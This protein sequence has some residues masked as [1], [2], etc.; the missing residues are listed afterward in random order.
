VSDARPDPAAAAPT[1]SQRRAPGAAAPGPVR[2]VPQPGVR[3]LVTL[4]VVAFSGLLVL[5]VLAGVPFVA[6]AV[7]L[8]GGV[9]AWGWAG[10]LGLPSPRGTTSVLAFGTAAAVLTGALTR[11]DP[12]LRWMPAA[13]ALSMLVAFLHQLLRRDGRPRLVESVVS[14]VTGLAVVVSG[15][16]LVPLALTADGGSVMAVAGAALGVAALV[17]LLARRVRLRP[18]LVPMAL[19][20]GTA[21]AVGVAA[22]FGS[23]SLPAAGLLGLFCAAV[24]STLRGVLGLLPAMSG[25]RSQLACA[26]AS[27]LGCGVVVYVVARLLVG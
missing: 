12:F 11:T 16:C 15:A 4:A 2:V 5:S 10:M 14:V 13:L 1:R 18:W 8:G 6:A 9:L 23:V 21:A 19:V 3:P 24:S 20:A 22:G 26:S 17:D 27:V 7:A 25:R